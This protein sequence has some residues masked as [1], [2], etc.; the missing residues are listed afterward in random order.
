MGVLFYDGES[1]KRRLVFFF[2]RKL[3]QKTGVWE[4]YL[5]SV[6]SNLEEIKLHDYL[7]AI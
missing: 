2:G 6:V 1:F 5:K 4:V 3:S 7:S